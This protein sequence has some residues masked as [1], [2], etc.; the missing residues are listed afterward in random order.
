MVTRTTTR[1]D[2]TNKDNVKKNPMIT[3][4]S[5]EFLVSPICQETTKCT[6]L[7]NNN[8]VI[9]RTDMV[10][11]CTS[12]LNVINKLDRLNKSY[13]NSVSSDTDL[14]TVCLAKVKEVSLTNV[15]PDCDTTDMV[16]VTTSKDDAMSKVDV[17]KSSIIISGSTES[18]TSPMSLETRKCTSLVINTHSIKKTDMVSESTSNMNVIKNEI[19]SEKPHTNSVPPDSDSESDENST[20]S[21]SSK[22]DPRWNSYDKKLMHKFNVTSKEIDDLKLA[23]QKLLHDKTILDKIRKA[24]LTEDEDTERTL[25]QNKEALEAENNERAKNLAERKARAARARKISREKKGCVQN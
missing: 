18:I 5:T 20:T 4:T 15:P 22:G 19:G 21:E 17:N 24:K 9:K 2:D 23:C 16:A 6:T 8:H 10:S 25:K 1:Q 13:T 11:E 14:D 7:V 12:T 3:R